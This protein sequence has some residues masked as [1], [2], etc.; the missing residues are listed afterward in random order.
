MFPQLLYPL[1]AYRSMAGPFLIVSAVVVPCWLAVRLYRRRTAG[2]GPTLRREVLLLV[3]VVYLSGLAA[4]TLTPNHS[5]RVMAEG[6][7]GVELRP[8]LA[9]LTCSAALLPSD[10]DRGFCVRNAMGNVALFLPLGILTPLVWRRLGFWKGLQIAI[11]VSFGIELVQYLSSAW[12]SYRAAD[13]NDVVLNVLGACGGLAL[14]LL[15]RS[16]RVPRDVT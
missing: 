11:A 14:G 3:F 1:L 12:G 5:S 4:A 16:L 2:R 6:A 7:G 10:V 13:V 8:S 15:P 9:S